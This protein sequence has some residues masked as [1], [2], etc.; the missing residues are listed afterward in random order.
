MSLP[1]HSA[2]C[3]GERATKLMVAAIEAYRFG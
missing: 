3:L 1:I 2:N